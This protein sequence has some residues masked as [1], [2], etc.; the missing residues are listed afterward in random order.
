MY[1]ADIGSRSRD[2]TSALGFMPAIALTGAHHQ[3]VGSDSRVGHRGVLGRGVLIRVGLCESFD[4][5]TCP[6]DG[7]EPTGQG[8]TRVEHSESPGLFSHLLG[9][10]AEGPGLLERPFVEVVTDR[11]RVA[12]STLRLVAS[13]APTSMRLSTLT[14]VSRVLRPRGCLQFSIGHPFTNTPIR[15]WVMK[16]SDDIEA[17]RREGQP[18]RITEHVGN[19]Q[20]VRLLLRSGRAHERL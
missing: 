20:R 4:N 19:P 12:F 5:E 13:G 10:G 8:P 2:A 3:K 14:E 7:I 17:L 11:E 18:G 15:R 1:A 6:D 16:R 9:S